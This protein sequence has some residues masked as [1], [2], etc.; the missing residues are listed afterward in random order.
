MYFFYSHS[1]TTIFSTMHLSP[2][3]DGNDVLFDDIIHKKYTTKTMEFKS[4]LWWM[5]DTFSALSKLLELKN[6][7]H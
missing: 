7:R 4:V 5:M 1:Q 3:H 6:Y 2:L